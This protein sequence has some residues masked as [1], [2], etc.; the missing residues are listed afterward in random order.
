V[1]Q[2][3]LEICFESFAK[4]LA[5]PS[6][7][8]FAHESE[9]QNAMQ[10]ARSF[11]AGFSHTGGATS[12]LPVWRRIEGSGDAAS[13]EFAGFCKCLQSVRI[14]ADLWTQQTITNSLSVGPC[15]NERKHSINRIFPDCFKI[16]SL[17]RRVCPLI[18]HLCKPEAFT[19]EVF[20]RGADQVKFL[21][22]DYQKAVMECHACLH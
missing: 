9:S 11:R 3:F 15:K 21:V 12:S 18:F 4:D 22:V 2:W 19:A 8:C 16:I 14:C 10:P 17:F 13:P 6:A 5:T 7:R 1:G 20:E